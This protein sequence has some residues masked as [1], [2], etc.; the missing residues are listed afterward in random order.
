MEMMDREDEEH[1]F[2]AARPNRQLHQSSSFQGDNGRAKAANQQ[3][4]ES[5]LSLC[6]QS[7]LMS[8]RSTTIANDQPSSSCSVNISV[9]R[10]REYRGYIG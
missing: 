2:H 10:E 3:L 9:N 1:G 4:V 5:L 8:H 6:K 7:A